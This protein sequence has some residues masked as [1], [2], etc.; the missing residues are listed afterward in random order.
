VRALY[1]APDL[2]PHTFLSGS[3]AENIA[4]SLGEA[5]VDLSYFFTKRR[6]MEHRKGLGLSEE[7]LPYPS[8]GEPTDSTYPLDQLPIGTVGAVALDVRGCIAAL[9]STGGRT[10][11]LVGRIGDTPVMGSGFWSEEWK[12]HGCLRSI[13]RNLRGKTNAHGVGVSG[14][15]DGDYFIRQST[16]ST[17]AHRVRFFGETLNQATSQT[18]K[19]LYEN[20][21]LGGVIAVDTSA[22]MSMPFNSPR[23]YRGV[24]KPDGVPKTALF[25]DDDLEYTRSRENNQRSR[26]N[27]K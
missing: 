12:K 6:W 22:N 5:F 15:G 17:I 18:V 2:A 21:G 26:V 10:N 7:P 1:L 13:W 11:K 27:G 16:A 8:H 20:G 4:E 25:A 24:I 9:T 23:M 3:A 14:T 19:D